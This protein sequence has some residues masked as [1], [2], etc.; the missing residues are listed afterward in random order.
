MLESFNK[1]FLNHRTGSKFTQK[2][3][4]FLLNLDKKRIG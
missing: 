3:S 1:F 4:P 2:S